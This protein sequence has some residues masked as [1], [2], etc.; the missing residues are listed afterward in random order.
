[1][2]AGLPAAERARRARVRLAAAEMI[3]AGAGD[4]EVASC[5]S[6]RATAVRAC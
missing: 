4:R 1:M 2:A 5:L 3:E 6:M